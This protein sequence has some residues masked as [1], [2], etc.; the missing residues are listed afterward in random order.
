MLRFIA[1]V[2][3]VMLAVRVG[4]MHRYRLMNIFLQVPLIRRM[5]VNFS[6]GSGNIPV[7]LITRVY[8]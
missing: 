7:G 2:L 4:Y 6:G 1:K 3:L 5:A 8:L